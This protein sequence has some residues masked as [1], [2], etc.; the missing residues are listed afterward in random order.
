MPEPALDF[1]GQMLWVG[2]GAGVGW[3][4]G[5]GS[6]GERWGFRW[7]WRRGCRAHLG[8]P[9]IMFIHLSVKCDPKA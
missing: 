5:S 4:L 3:G 8:T 2:G 9:S 6:W 7:L 1:S